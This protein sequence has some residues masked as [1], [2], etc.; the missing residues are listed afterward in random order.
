MPASARSTDSEIAVGARRRRDPKPAETAASPEP[1]DPARGLKPWPPGSISAARLLLAGMSC[2]A[3]VGFAAGVQP[4]LAIAASFALAFVVIVIADLARGWSLFTFLAFLEI[5]PFG[6]PALSFTKLLGLLLLI[7][8]LAVMTTQRGT[9]FDAR[10][11][12]RRLPACRAARLGDPERHLGGA[13]GCGAG[14]CLALR[15]QRDAVHHHRDLGPRALDGDPAARRRSSP[16]PAWRRSTGSSAPDSSRPSTDGSRAPR[17]TRT[18][19][20]RCSSPGSRICLFAALGCAG[21]R[22]CGSR[23]SSWEY[24]AA[25][26]SCSPSRA[27]G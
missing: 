7:S 2:W 8:W 15:A 27:A 19:S 9:R 18:S 12:R 26:R 13:A 16:A 23:R 10:V 17:W 11:V 25:P 6:G 4:E 5:V 24:S 20:R 21:R 22:W 1:R 14:R 3:T